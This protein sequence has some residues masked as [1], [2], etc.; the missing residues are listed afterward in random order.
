MN[1]RDS[2]VRGQIAEAERIAFE[3]ELPMSVRQL[4]DLLSHLNA[5]EECAHD[6]A[7]TLEFLE[8]NGLDPAKVLPWLEERGGHCDCEIIYNVY[9]AVGEQLG[10]HLDA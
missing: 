4:K 9:D 6:Y 5:K 7:D 8:R 10:W 3:N 1:E 2:G